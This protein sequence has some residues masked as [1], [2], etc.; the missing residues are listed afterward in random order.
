LVPI[1]V[2]N[3]A[4]LVPSAATA[5]SE[6]FDNSRM[7]KRVRHLQSE[8]DAARFTISGLSLLP[9]IVANTQKSLEQ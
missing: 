5:K 7:T 2:D 6:Q 3:G 4:G 8:L 1:S 9:E